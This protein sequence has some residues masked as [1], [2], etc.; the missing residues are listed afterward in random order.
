MLGYEE[1]RRKESLSRSSGRGRGGRGGVASLS[2]LPT[3]SFPSVP[4]SPA[5]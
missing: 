1:E 4:P 2:L 3:H 5:L